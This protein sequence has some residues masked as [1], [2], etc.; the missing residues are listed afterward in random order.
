MRR[1]FSSSLVVLLTGFLTLAGIGPGSPEQ[2][3][4]SA[5]PANWTLQAGGYCQRTFEFSG[6][7]QTWIVPS[8]VSSISV[9]MHGAAGGSGGPSTI[10]VGGLGGRVQANLT[11][12]AGDSLGLYVGGVGPSNVLSVLTGGWNGG[13]GGAPNAG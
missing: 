2:A 7:L 9:D 10:G 4:A 6:A 8:G 3:A 12:S 13:G 11:V 1:W 5:C